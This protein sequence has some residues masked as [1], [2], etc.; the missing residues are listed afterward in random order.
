MIRILVAEDDAVSRLLVYKYI[1]KYFEDYAVFLSP[2]G[3]HALETLENNDF[4]ILITDI[5]MPIMNGVE[6]AEI[7]R[8]KEKYGQMPI[9][10]MSAVRDVMDLP[11]SL[12][13]NSTYFLDKPINPGKL[14]EYIHSS[15]TWW[16]EN[17]ENNN[18]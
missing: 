1:T 17:R 13:K 9:I 3:K 14:I 4:D 2:N 18:S 11:K 15:V 5:M 6:L 7:V 16:R 8:G 12:Q 10:V